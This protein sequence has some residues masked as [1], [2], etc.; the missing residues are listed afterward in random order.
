MVLG[1]LFFVPLLFFKIK[2]ACEMIQHQLESET[3]ANINWR[4][5]RVLVKMLDFEGGWI[6]RSYIS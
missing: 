1:L 6:V 4:V 3:S 5:K 2:G